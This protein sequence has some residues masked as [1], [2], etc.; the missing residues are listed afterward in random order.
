MRRVSRRWQNRTLSRGGIWLVAR[1]W[2]GPARRIHEPERTATGPRSQR[3]QIEICFGFVGTRSPSTRCDRGPVAVRFFM[4]PA[5][6]TSKGRAKPLALTGPGKAGK[7][8]SAK[9]HE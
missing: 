7:T 1:K 8:L 2:S 3:P 9:D 6:K 4:H 5:L